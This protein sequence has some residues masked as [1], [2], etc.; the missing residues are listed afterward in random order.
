VKTVTTVMIRNNIIM[1]LTFH[2]VKRAMMF[3]LAPMGLMMTILEL[4]GGRTVQQ[5]LA[6]RNCLVKTP[7]ISAGILHIIIA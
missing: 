7:M 6:H 1:N 3:I 5:I 2:T 4:V